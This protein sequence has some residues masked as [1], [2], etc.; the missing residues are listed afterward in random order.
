MLGD[1]TEVGGRMTFE[2]DM[3]PRGGSRPRVLG[4]ALGPV[5]LALC[6]LAGCAA[7]PDDPSRAAIGDCLEAL[8]DGKKT[9]EFRIVD[10]AAP[11]AAYKTVR[12]L[13]G[14][15]H[16]GSNTYGYATSGYSRRKRGWHLCLTLNAKEGDCFRQQVGFPTGKAVKVA[17][18]ASATYRV[19]KVVQGVADKAECGEDAV[20]PVRNDLARPLALAYPDPPLTICTDRA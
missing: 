12:R 18:G 19:T 20:D 11:G 1:L 15:A 13:E 8:G 17:C 3:S 2:A 14:G 9:G 5:V 4:A 7:A 16:C 6:V 10:C